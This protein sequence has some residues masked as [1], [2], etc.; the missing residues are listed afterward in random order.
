MPSSAHVYQIKVT[1]IDIRPL[2]W[3]RFRVYSDITFRDL[4]NILQIVMGW[5]NYHLY[6]FLLSSHQFV[7]S[8]LG[9]GDKPATHRLD[10]FV[11]HEGAV[12]RYEYDF[13]DSWQHDLELEKILAYTR[14]PCPI[15]THG[16]RAC[17][18]ED[19]GGAW[20]YQELVAA[21]KRR[22]GSEY[23]HYV[24][25]LG[26]PFDPQAFDIDDVNSMLAD[27]Q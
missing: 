11:Q 24:E 20:G 15:C 6:Q 21:M 5:E 14:K 4:H 19:S 23:R 22:R 8:Q 27:F 25:W 12:L 18:P 2:I 10:E 9:A 13:G 17:P 26:G 7:E 1:L 16:R 3:R